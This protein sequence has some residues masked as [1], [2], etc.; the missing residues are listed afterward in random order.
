MCTGSQAG[1]ARTAAATT[2]LDATAVQ[3]TVTLFHLIEPF[4]QPLAQS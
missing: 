2:A 1:A 3:K 4:P